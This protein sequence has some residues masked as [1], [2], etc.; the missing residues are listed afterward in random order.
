[1]AS[2]GWLLAA[3]AA[4]HFV[5]STRGG[6]IRAAMP[7]RQLVAAFSLAMAVLL[8]VQLSAAP[9][10]PFAVAVFCVLGL[11]AGVRTPA[12][13]GLGLDQLPEHP[14]AMMAARTAVT[15]LGYL[16]GSLIGGAVLAGYGFGTL[17]IVLA[18]GM[19]A[20]A[21]L[22]LRVVDPLEPAAGDRALRRSRAS[23]EPRARRVLGRPLMR[24]SPACESADRAGNHIAHDRADDRHREV[25]QR[26]DD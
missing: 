13:S 7:R 26:I 11:A 2:V 16:L 12:A 17:G 18:V 24:V 4:A 8:V 10:A 3:G 15:Q 22:T 20:S 14:G 6:R 23:L 5:A 21:W 9:P 25:E 1:E 19:A